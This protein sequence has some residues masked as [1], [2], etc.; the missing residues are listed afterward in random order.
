MNSLKERRTRKLRTRA[1]FAA[2]LDP[3]IQGICEASLT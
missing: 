1:G 2:K 3:A